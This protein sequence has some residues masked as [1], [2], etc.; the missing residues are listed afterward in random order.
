MALRGSDQR[1]MDYVAGAVELLRRETDL[2]VACSLGLLPREQAVELASFGVHRYNHN[3][4][5]WRSFLP[6]ICTTRRQLP[7]PEARHALG[8]PADPQTAPRRSA[9]SLY[10]V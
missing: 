8:R 9:Q 2:N 5:S 6:K 4:E 3:L 10:F 1:T 7:Q